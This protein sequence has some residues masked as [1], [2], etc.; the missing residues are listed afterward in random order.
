ME[1]FKR[2]LA[3]FMGTF[4]LVFG[5]CGAIAANQLSGG[6]IGAMGI[7]TAFGLIVMTMIYAT[8]HVSGGHLNP[9]VT[10][11]FA[12]AKKFPLREAPCYILSQCA[13]ATAAS[14]FLKISL[15]PFLAQSQPGVLLN[16][17][18]TAPIDGLFATA[19]IWEFLL[20]FLLMVVIVSV[21][22]DH[23]AVGEMAGLAVGCAVWT[24]AIFAGMISGAS[25]N[26]AR[27]FGPALV[28]GNWHNFGAYVL[29]PVLGAIAGMAFYRFIRAGGQPHSK[30]T[31]PNHGK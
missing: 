10:L 23:R 18:V 26:P 28:S 9:A 8:G 31:G 11:A 20:T 3:E 25:M 13:G 5:G 2:C 7:A 1:L 16:I 30:G 12:V 15:S 17:G 19:L 14:L 6:Q 22:T 21:A 24:E 29:G 27:S 4:T